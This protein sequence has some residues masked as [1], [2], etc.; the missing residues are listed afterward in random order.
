MGPGNA[1]IALGSIRSQHAGAHPRHRFRQKAA[2]AADVEQ[3]QAFERPVRLR[4]AAELLADLVADIGNADR[5]ELVQR[6]ELAGRIPPFRSHGGKAVHFRLIDRGF[7]RFAHGPAPFDRAFIRLRDEGAT[8]L[9]AVLAQSA[10][11]R[12]SSFAADSRP[13]S[14]RGYIRPAMRFR[15]KPMEGV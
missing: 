10:P 13:P 1:D 5:I 15:I 11:H 4:I 2:A 12:D 8:P 7:R 14:V 3:A 9:P 6:L